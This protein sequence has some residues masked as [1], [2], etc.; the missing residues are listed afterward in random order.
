MAAT[1]RAGTAT[2]ADALAAF[3][4]E[5][6]SAPRFWGNE[7]DA[8]YGPHRHGFHK[9]LFCLSGSIVFHTDAGAIE[10]EAGCRLDIEPGTSHSATVG[11]EGCDCVEASR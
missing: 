6:C 5:G 4:A 11:P 10:V 7:P 1:A 8:R 3:E 9:V 2:R